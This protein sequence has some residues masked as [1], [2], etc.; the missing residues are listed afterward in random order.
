MNICY[1]AI[2]SQSLLRGR[3]IYLQVAGNFVLSDGVD[4][5]QSVLS[6][7][8]GVESHKLN[9]SLE[10]S[11]V[12]DTGLHLKAREMSGEDVNLQLFLESVTYLL[13][14][15]TNLLVFQ[16]GKERIPGGR[17]EERVKACRSHGI[18]GK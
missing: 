1:D 13:Q 11:Q 3:F 6:G 12:I 2:R 5:L 10:L 17:L 15:G 7:V 9:N 4:I 8:E 16:D 14:K 18:K